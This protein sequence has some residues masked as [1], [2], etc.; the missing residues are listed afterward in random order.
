LIIMS[1]LIWSYSFALTQAIR[2]AGCAV[3]GDPAARSAN[4][5]AMGTDQPHVLRQAI[6]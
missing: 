2:W 5:Q 4:P 1:V 3:T 6:H